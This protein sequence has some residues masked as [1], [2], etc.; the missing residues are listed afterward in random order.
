MK[1]EYKKRGR[2]NKDYWSVCFVFDKEENHFCSRGK[3]DYMPKKQEIC[4]MIKC[5]L[6]VE[7]DTKREIMKKQFLKA[8]EDGINAEH[9]YN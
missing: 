9:K 6:E 2:Y 5:L 3:R 1:T 4:D 7:P 8:I